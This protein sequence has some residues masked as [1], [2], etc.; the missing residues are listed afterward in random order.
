MGS[1][2]ILDLDLIYVSL[3]LFKI[4]DFYGY[5]LDILIILEIEF[6]VN[7]F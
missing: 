3:E 6:L 1:Y 2:N 5:Y 4:L 7:D